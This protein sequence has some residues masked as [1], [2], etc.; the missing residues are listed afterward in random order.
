MFLR[1]S[2][3]MFII[4]SEED[5]FGGYWQGGGIGYTFFD[6]ENNRISYHSS[7]KRQ[8]VLPQRKSYF[9]IPSSGSRTAWIGQNL[10]C[11]MRGH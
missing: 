1:L 7:I 4:S 5:S 10:K 3:G 9:I 2:P 8:F 6:F 11:D